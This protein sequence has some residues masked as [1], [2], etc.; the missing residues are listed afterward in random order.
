MDRSITTE[1]N[2][3]QAMLLGLCAVLLW[4]TVA[5]AFKLSLQYLTP[6]QLVAAA[7]VVSTLVLALA[8]TINKQWS[9]LLH[10]WRRTPGRYLLLGAI[11]PCLYYAVLFQAY[12]L[13]PA[14]QAQPL[15]YT[16]ALTLSLLAV[17]L[18]GQPLRRSDLLAMALGYLGV[19]VISTRG[20]LTG[21]QFDSPLGVLLAMVSTVIWALYWIFNAR[22]DA[23]ATVGLLLCFL[24][25][26]PLVI[27]LT[28]LTD[29]FDM[30]PQG[31]LGAAYVG[32]F[33]M[34][35]TFMLWLSAMK[36][37]SHTSRVSNL[38][39]L[40]PF[41]SLIFINQLLGEQIHPATYIGL[42]LIVAAV[43]FQQWAAQRAKR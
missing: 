43:G 24:N 5:T 42:V 6:F 16:W 35:L 11:N 33:E 21:L 30:A 13:L 34:G 20:D 40:S 19:L 26:L 25:S 9:T 1:K 27:L 18:L 2:Q 36:K 7:S 10:Y 17:P 12:D 22:N 38:I 23:P 39:F 41:I 15:N 31:L 14:Q 29:G 32:L 3:R 4:S 8:V 28:A 37:A